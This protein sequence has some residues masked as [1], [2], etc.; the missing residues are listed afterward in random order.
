MEVSVSNHSSSRVHELLPGRACERHQA[1]NV[2]GSIATADS[3]YSVAEDG[4]CTKDIFTIKLS[5]TTKSITYGNQLGHGTTL[6]F[7]ASVYRH[8]YYLV[9]ALH[10]VNHIF[11]YV[12]DLFNCNISSFMSDD[13]HAGDLQQIAL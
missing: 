6:L 7:L 8:F 2:D 3:L 10:I 13:D 11:F 4:W 5:Y 9:L 12:G 1:D